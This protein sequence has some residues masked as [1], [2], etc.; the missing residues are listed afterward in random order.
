MIDLV[1]LVVPAILLSYALITG[2]YQLYSRAVYGTWL[3]HPLRAKTD[4]LEFQLQESV[5]QL[6][7]QREQNKQLQ[8]DISRVQQAILARSLPKAP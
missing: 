8:E 6:A 7:E 3:Y 2:A 4:L 1:V 5:R